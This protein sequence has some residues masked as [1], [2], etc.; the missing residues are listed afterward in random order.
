MNG[1]S[2][3]RTQAAIDEGELHVD[4]M[5]F[6]AVITVCLFAVLSAVGGQSN[7]AQTQTAKSSNTHETAPSASWVGNVGDEVE[8]LP[9]FPTSQ[10]MRF[11]DHFAFQHAVVSGAVTLWKFNAQHQYK[12]EV[13][14]GQL[15]PSVMPDELFFT[16]D[17]ADVIKFLE[18][19]NSRRGSNGIDGNW[20]ITL[21]KSTLSQVGQELQEAE[22]WVI[23]DESASIARH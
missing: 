5:R 4:V 10:G 19:V 9:A 1:A 18:Q 20:Y 12:Y 8:E 23:L 7:H 2:H 14:A 11:K 22:G 13:E 6:F 3:Y 17:E 16:I 21:P 15:L